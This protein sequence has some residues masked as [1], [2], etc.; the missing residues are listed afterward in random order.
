MAYVCDDFPQQQMILIETQLTKGDTVSEASCCLDRFTALAEQYRGYGLQA[1]ESYIGHP[2]QQAISGCREDMVE[3]FVG[4]VRARQRSGTL[5]SWI[6]IASGRIGQ[7]ECNAWFLNRLI[8]ALADQA[9]GSPVQEH[10]SSGGRSPT[11]ERL[12]VLLD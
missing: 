5:A 7:E 2:R 1:G 11:V 10:T 6:Q 8:T 12:R 4:Y 3:A 9:I